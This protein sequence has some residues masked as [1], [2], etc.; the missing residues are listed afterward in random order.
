MKLKKLAV[1]LLI[2]AIASSSIVMPASA[3]APQTC[4]GSNSSGTTYSGRSDVYETYGSARTSSGRS[5]S[6]VSAE[7]KYTYKDGWGVSHTITRSNSNTGQT[8]A[9][10]D[11]GKAESVEGIHGGEGW[12]GH[13]MHVRPKNK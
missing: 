2:S 12:S 4:S 10:V 1:G 13:T 3:L 11:G 9:R 5:T 8:S 6:G 7:A